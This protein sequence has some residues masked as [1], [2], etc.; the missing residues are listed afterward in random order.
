MD[1][2]QILKNKQQTFNWSDKIP[3]RKIIDQILD[4]LH[5]YC[6][7]KQNSVP[8]KLEVLDWS[9]KER[10]NQIFKDTWCESDTLD[11]RRNPQ[12]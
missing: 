5:N 11:D 9:N 6:P 12:V 2:Q 1:W 10:R 4:E 7:S 3:D 8:Y